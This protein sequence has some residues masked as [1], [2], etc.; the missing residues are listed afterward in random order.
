MQNETKVDVLAVMDAA[1]IISCADKTF[2]TRND[3]CAEAYN[4]ADAMLR[5]REVQS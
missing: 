4:Y 3:E 2:I 1:L 5:A